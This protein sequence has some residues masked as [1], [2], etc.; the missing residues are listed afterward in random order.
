MTESSLLVYCSSRQLLR[1][2]APV[3]QEQRHRA[4]R[5]SAAQQLVYHTRTRPQAN[6]RLHGRQVVLLG[7]VVLPGRGMSVGRVNSFFSFRDSSKGQIARS[8]SGGEHSIDGAAASR[9][10]PLSGSAP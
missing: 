10:T 3:R 9:G 7:L 6:E 4:L 2:L 1:P 5:A 8:G